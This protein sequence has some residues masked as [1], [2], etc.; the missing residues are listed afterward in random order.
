MS[1]SPRVI[2]AHDGAR[3]LPRIAEAFRSAR[4]RRWQRVVAVDTGTMQ[5]WRGAGRRLGR[6]VVFGMDRA[7]GYGVPVPRRARHRAASNPRPRASGLP[8]VDR[9]EWSGC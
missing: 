5:P 3:L 1:L 2:V 8:Q 4:T 6:S 9:V 7:T